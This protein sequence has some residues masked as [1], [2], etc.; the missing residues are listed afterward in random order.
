MSCV[1]R[2]GSRTRRAAA[3][4]SARIAV[5]FDSTRYQPLRFSGWSRSMVLLASQVA[6]ASFSQMSSHHGIVTRFPNHM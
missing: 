4:A 6:K 3:R 1:E 2:I 5:C